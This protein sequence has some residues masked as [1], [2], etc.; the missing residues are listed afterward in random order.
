MEHLTRFFE[1]FVFLSLSGVFSG[2]FI[3]GFV[4]CWLINGRRLKGYKEIMMIWGKN[5]GI[6]AQ[7]QAAQHI[8]REERKLAKRYLELSL[9]G[10]DPPDPV[11]N[12]EEDPSV[13]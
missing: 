4:S 2:G 11:I 9:L 13:N 6:L 10:M 3:I 1:V 5:S 8:A 12:R 7:Y